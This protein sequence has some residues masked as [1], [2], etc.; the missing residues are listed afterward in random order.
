M[1]FRQDAHT[2]MGIDVIIVAVNGNGTKEETSK[3][4]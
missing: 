3:H 2:V 4:T 1:V